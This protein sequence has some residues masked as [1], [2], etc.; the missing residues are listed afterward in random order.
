M[1]ILDDI[2]M[3]GRPSL[4]EVLGGSASFVTLGQRLFADNSREVGCLGIIGDDFLDTVKEK[5]ESWGITLVMQTRTG[6]KSTRG[7]LSYKDDTFGRTYT[8]NRLIIFW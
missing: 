1:I 4:K 3:P 5:I 2:H 7:K 8:P 6:E